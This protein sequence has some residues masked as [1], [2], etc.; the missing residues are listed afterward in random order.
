PPLGQAF[1]MVELR[2]AD[3]EVLSIDYGT[4]PPQLTRGRSVRLEDLRLTGLR[5]ESAKEERARQF[6][7]P[8]CGA[9]VEVTLAS[10]KAITCRSCH[11]LIDMSQGI[12][13]ELRHAQQDAT[14]E[15][16]IP[17]GT[18]GQLQGVQW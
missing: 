3:G 5:E 7:C 16:L 15:P 17:L 8:N 6:N 18:L 9:P 1:S 2:S 11:S 4:Q 10:S 14:I 12:G 13:G